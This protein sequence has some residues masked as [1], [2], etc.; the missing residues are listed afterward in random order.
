MAAE[1]SKINI[2]RLD[3]VYCPFN[4]AFSFPHTY[5]EYPTTLPSETASR[6]ASADIVITTRVVLDSAILHQWTAG[7]QRRKLIAAFAI[8]TDHLD[9]P[10]CRELNVAVSN[11]P[12][13]SNE[14]V[15]EHAIALYFAARRNVVVMHDIVVASNVWPSKGSA[16][17]EFGSLPITNKG[18]VMG[19]IGLGDLGKFGH[20]AKKVQFFNVMTILIGRRV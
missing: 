15:A 7:S 2:V 10:T 18:E 20:A 16:V 6:I 19:I 12:G 3:G 1:A 4:P 8:G 9:I 13:A 5:T 14:A 11:V 17:A